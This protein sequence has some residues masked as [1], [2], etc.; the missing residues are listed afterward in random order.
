MKLFSSLA[1]VAIVA[2]ILVAVGVHRRSPI[3]E[4]LGV[5]DAEP[6]NASQ[7]V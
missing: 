2:I 3:S 5:I 7:P 4:D 6:N 1:P